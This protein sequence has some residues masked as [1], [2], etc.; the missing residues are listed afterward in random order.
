MTQGKVRSSLVYGPRAE[1]AN[2]NS[3]ALISVSEAGASL[4]HPESAGSRVDLSDII[5]IFLLSREISY[6]K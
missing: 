5:L 3:L 1:A 6:R 4:T 2:S